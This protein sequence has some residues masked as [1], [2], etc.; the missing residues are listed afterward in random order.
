MCAA[1]GLD[2]RRPLRAAPAV[3]AARAALRERV[4]SLTA[5]RPLSPDIAAAADVVRNG[6]LL[7]AATAAGA[8][9]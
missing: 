6:R 2:L 7:A 5:D 8:T 9:P 3:E 1:Q 4:A